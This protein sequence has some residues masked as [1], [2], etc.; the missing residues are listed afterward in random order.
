M[1]ERSSTQTMAEMWFTLYSED[2]YLLFLLCFFRHVSS[3]S[4]VIYFIVTIGLAKNL[5]QILSNI[6]NR[7]PSQNIT[8]TRCLF[9]HK[10]QQALL[11]F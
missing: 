2:L 11:K 10:H 4:L 6:M 8:L 1:R 9:A 7:T 5:F 3:N